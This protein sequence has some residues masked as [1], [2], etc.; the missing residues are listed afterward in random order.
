MD[1]ER[2]M[3]DL[4]TP[5]VDNKES[6]SV[7]VLPTLEDDEVLLNVYAS[8]EDVARLIGRR[9]IMASSL[10]QMMSIASRTENKMITIK[11]ESY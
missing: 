8:S 4:I 1:Y 3:L 5:I 9:G 2:I 7:K 6:L 10:R 11:F